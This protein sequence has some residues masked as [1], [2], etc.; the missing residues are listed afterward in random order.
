M[1]RKANNPALLALM[2][3]LG[4]GQAAA[5]TPGEALVMA[6]ERDPALAAARAAYD[7][8]AELG[9]QERSQLRPTLGLTGEGYYND[10]DSTFAF[11]SAKESYRSWSAYLRARQPLLRMDWSARGDRADAR[12]QLAKEGLADRE[13]T[14]VARVSQRYIDTLL[15]EDEIDQAESEASAV[16]ESLSDTRK[17]FEV[18]LVPG[19]DLKEAQARDDL[20]QAQLVSARASVE[21]ARDALEEVTGYD[22]SRL[23]RLR[24]ELEFPPLDPVDI[25]SWLKIA[26]ENSTATRDAQL[27]VKLATTDLASRRADAW[28]TIDAV[29]QAGRADSLDYTLGQRQDDLRV[30][31]ELNLPIYAGGYNSSR[32]REAEARLKESQKEFERASL[33]TEREVRS[34]FRATQTARARTAAYSRALDS[35]VLAE[36]AARAGYDAGTRTI[37]DVLDAKSRVVQARRTRN[38]ARYDLLTQSLLLYAASGTLDVPKVARTD[39][40]FETR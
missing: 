19:T 25:E 39:A 7:A 29:A 26:A 9:E 30:G 6:A 40:L 5:I 2:L 32:V 35:A 8:E 33:E 20:A 13:R 11:G 18:E 1:N 27:R 22:R 3:G 23:P 16:R 21:Q 31:L 24:E 28:P 34:R 14:F 4:V 37:T 17:R 12:D 38:A 36:A 10:S 15:A